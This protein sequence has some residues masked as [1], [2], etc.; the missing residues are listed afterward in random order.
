[1][2][3]QSETVLGVVAVVYSSALANLSVSVYFSLL[4]GK[5]WNIILK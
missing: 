2:S 4:R 3:Q 5:A 1:M